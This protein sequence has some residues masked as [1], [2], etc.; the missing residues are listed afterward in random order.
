MF[1]VF[2][3]YVVQLLKSDRQLISIGCGHN[4]QA[5]DSSIG[6]F[7]FLDDAIERTWINSDCARLCGRRT[8]SAL[9]FRV[10]EQIRSLV[11]GVCLVDAIRTQ[12]NSSDNF[13]RIGLRSAHKCRGILHG[14][15]RKSIMGQVTNHQQRYASV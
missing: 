3:L 1:I 4:G 5:I 2:N 6:A 15:A 8:W 14:P 7:R 11:L 10:W 13:V 12:R 9:V